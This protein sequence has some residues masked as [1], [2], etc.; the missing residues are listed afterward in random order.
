VRR[1]LV[2]IL[3][4]VVAVVGCAQRPHPG[5]VADVKNGLFYTTEEIRGLTPSERDAYCESLDGQIKD[6]R[7]EAAQLLASAES[8]SKGADSLK[9]LNTALVSQIRDLDN[10]IRQLRL[11]RRSAT[12]YLVKAGDTLQSI[13]TEIYG[14]PDQ[15]KQIY[16]ANTDILKSATEP[17]KPG[18]RLTIPAT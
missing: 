12:T 18:I 16:D 10:E 13:S 4:A 15:W 2:L 17:L 5:K 1:S 9:T 14:K 11:A 3:L 6:Y 8:L 7:S